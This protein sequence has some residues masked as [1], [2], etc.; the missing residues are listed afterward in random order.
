MKRSYV[1]PNPIIDKREELALL[2]LT[3][4]YEKLIQPG[5][6]AKVGGKVGGLIPEKVKQIGSNVKGSVT[7]AEL[8]EQCMKVVADGFNILEQQAAKLT[9]S[10]RAIVQTLNKT[11]KD[12]KITTLDEVCFARSYDIAKAV[13]S[14]KIQD[15]GLSFVEGG[16]TGFFGFPG[17]PFNIVLSIFLYYRAVQSVAM[18]YGYDVKNDAAELVIASEVFVN[19]LNPNGDSSDEMGS[20]IG[21]VMVMTELTTVRQTVKKGWEEMAKTGGLALALTQMR[22]LA[23]TSAK[24]ALEKSGKKSIES[25]LFKKVFTQI[26]KKITQDAVKKAIPFV[27]A[28]IG[29]LFDT[30]QMNKVLEYADVFYNK[31]FILEKENK[32][33]DLIS[34]KEEVVLD[35]IDV[36]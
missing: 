29:A 15:M 1:V 7:E 31:R 3:D 18:F 4:R 17:L 12:N 11:M 23:H 5:V 27:G 36:Q 2:T 34:V 19:A 26:G 20:V 24:K 10:E 13:N 25:N 14:Y 28:A 6:I 16:V 30:A 9:I 35:V 33:N 21:K 32:I 8:F 22:A